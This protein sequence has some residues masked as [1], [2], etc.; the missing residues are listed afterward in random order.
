[1]AE[2]FASYFQGKIEKIRDLLKDKPKYTARP[3]DVPELV[4]FHPTHGQPGQ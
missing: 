3:T 4:K 2:D 1:M